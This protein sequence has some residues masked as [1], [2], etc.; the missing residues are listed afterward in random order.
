MGK[1]L[2]IL[3]GIVVIFLASASYYQ[4]SHNKKTSDIEFPFENTTQNTQEQ[5]PNVEKGKFS[6]TVPGFT[7]SYPEAMISSSFGSALDEAGETILIQDS[8]GKNGAQVLITPFD[9]DIV[10][11]ESRIKKE[12]PDLKVMNAK[13]IV[14]GVNPNSPRVPLGVKAVQFESENSSMGKSLETWFVYEKMLYQIS[15]PIGSREVYDKIV[16]TWQWK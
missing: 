5:K 11:T 7:F 10:L 8:T 15:A 9:E 1:G 14:I 4:Y 12:L 6:N 3:I 16:D 13:E 2:K